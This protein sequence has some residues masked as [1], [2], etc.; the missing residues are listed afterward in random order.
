MEEAFDALIPIVL[1]LSVLG[2]LALFRHYRFRTQQQVHE[3]LREALARGDSLTP[4]ILDAMVPKPDPN[5]DR[6]K[7]VLS[8]MV[9][10]AMVGFALVLGEPDAIGPLLGLACFPLFLSVAYFWLARSPNGSA[11]GS[12]DPQP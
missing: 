5:A 9:A 1:F 2:G 8:L 10:L 4:E 7:A 12:P 6:R 11:S 3:T